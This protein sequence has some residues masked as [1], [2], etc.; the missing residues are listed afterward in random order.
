MINI[1]DI[2]IPYDEFVHVDGLEY[3][4]PTREVAYGED[5]HTM[6]IPGGYELCEHCDGTGQCEC[7]DGWEGKCEYGCCD[8]GDDGYFPQFDL[9]GWC[10]A[11]GCLTATVNKS[12]D[13]HLCTEHDASRHVEIKNY[14]DRY[15]R[16]L[17]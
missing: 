4:S 16:A 8:C 13:E 3:L 10:M 1:P 9:V 15:E 6:A 2:P 17:L 5:R 11:D 7:N 12:H 14:P